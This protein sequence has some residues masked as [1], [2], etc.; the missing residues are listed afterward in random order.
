MGF[1]EVRFPTVISR[2]ATSGPSTL[3]H[4]IQLDSGHEIRTARYNTPRWRGDA[5][6]GIKRL[7]QLQEVT[8]FYRARNGPANGFRYKDFRDFATNLA[9]ETWTPVGKATPVSELDVVLGT[10]DGS[11]TQFQLRKV[12][13]SGGVDSVRNLTKIVSGTVKVALN[14]TLQTEGT[15][16]SVNYNTGIITFNTAPG[17]GVEVTAGCE[18]DV[19]VRFGDEIDFEGLLASV[20]GFDMGSIPSVPLVEVLEEL[21]VQ[22]DF[23]FGG[24]SVISTAVDVSVTLLSGRTIT[25]NPTASGVK[26]LLP[27]TKDNLEGGGPYWFFRNVHGSNSF[28]LR[29]GTAGG[30][31]IATIAAG[32]AKTV[33]LGLNTSSVKTWYAL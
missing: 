21:E 18:F 25:V 23:F 31:L 9:G 30:A 19:P 20:E 17:V 4:I 16:Y 27:A 14:G 5:R 3:T 13:S 8:T 12:Y 24:A 2:A 22:D 11:K 32:A 28:E 6:Q 1:H 33:V 15:H 10:G 29:D 7:E 26:I